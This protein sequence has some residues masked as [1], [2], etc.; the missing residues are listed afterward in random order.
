MD[1]RSALPDAMLNLITDIPGIN[2]GHAHDAA[3]ASGVTAILF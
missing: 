3:L 1:R 2:V